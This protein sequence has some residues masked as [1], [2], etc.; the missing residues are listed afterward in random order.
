MSIIW[1]AVA[2]LKVKQINSFL[3]TGIAAIT[4]KLSFLCIKGQTTPA[5][6]TSYLQG[7]LHFPPNSRQVR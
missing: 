1:I 3:R 2:N 7:F 6:R 5:Q 4:V